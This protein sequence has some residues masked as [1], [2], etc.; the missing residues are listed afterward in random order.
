[1]TWGGIGLLFSIVI[2][3]DPD[4]HGM[5]VMVVVPDADSDDM[6]MMVV[7]PDPD[8]NTVMMMMVVVVVMSDLHRDLRQLCTLG[9]LATG[10]ALIIGSQDWD[11]I[12]NWIEQ[13]S[14]G[15]GG[16]QLC[17]LRWGCLGG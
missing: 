1:M 3:V 5:V 11:R 4:S 2:A 13:I 10:Q 14:I 8:A 17:R 9:R 16:R 6:V 15:G 7:V 12:R